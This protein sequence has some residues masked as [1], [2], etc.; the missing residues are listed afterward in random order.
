MESV[1]KKPRQDQSES[2]TLRVPGLIYV[3]PIKSFKADET[4]FAQKP[5]VKISYLGDNFRRRFA[6]TVEENPA[7]DP[8]TCFTLLRV[9]EDR[10]ILKEL[11]SAASAAVALSQIWRLMQQS[12]GRRG[13]LLTDGWA[14]VFYCHDKDEVLCAVSVRWYLGGW[15]VCVD[16]LGVRRWRIGDN[17]FFS[18]DS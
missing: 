6:G 12:S 13:G 14:N 1:N 15:S 4:F 5:G 2:C 7:S 9:A 16:N 3:P 10:K 11:G 8:L 18:R 17:R